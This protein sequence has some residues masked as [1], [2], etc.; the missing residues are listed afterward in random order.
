MNTQEG[1]GLRKPRR[2]ADQLTVLIKERA[3]RYGPWPAKM[4]MLIY[5]MN[6]TWEVMVSK[7]RSGR[8]IRG[9]RFVDCDRDAGRV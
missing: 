6:D 5:P 8:R 9:H 1:I 4:P 2:T 7:N 3:A